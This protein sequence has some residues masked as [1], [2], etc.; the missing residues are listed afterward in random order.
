MKIEV[1]TT[2]PTTGEVLI[3]GEKADGVRAIT[4]RGRVGDLWL[5]E[6]KTMAEVEFEGDGFAD[7]TD[8]SDTH[9]RYQMVEA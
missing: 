9:R 3:N 7:V 8:V 2:G 6:M 1:R 5:V 4:I